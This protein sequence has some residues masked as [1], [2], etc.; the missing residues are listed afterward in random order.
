M[1]GDGNV[2]EAHHVAP[3]SP[4]VARAGRVSRPLKYNPYI[5]LGRE[6]VD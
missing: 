4:R 2:C 3:S 6:P 5:T 1:K